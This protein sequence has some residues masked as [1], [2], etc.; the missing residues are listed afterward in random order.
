MNMIPKPL[1][2]KWTMIGWHAIEINQNSLTDDNLLW[3][4]NY[5]SSSSID[6][7][8]SSLTFFF[9]H[10]SAN[11][12]NIFSRCDSKQ[13]W[14]F[15]SYT[16]RNQWIIN[17]YILGSAYHDLMTTREAGTIF[18]LLFTLLL[19]SFLASNKQAIKFHWIWEGWPDKEKARDLWDTQ[20]RGSGSI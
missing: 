1:S 4:R 5:F 7:P 6:L 3:K 10:Q 18:T 17:I 9:Q 16:I 2:I 19:L 14:R 13:V 12:T 15:S 11:I 20:I 8:Y